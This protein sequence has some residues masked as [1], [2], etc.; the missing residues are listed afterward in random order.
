MPVSDYRVRKMDLDSYDNVAEGLE[1]AINA[2]A[3]E[4]WE[5][6]SCVSQPHHPD[7]LGIHE[8]SPTDSGEDPYDAVWQKPMGPTFYAVFRRLPIS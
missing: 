3:Q 7:L 1:S 8:T 2:L 6:V 4:G 5:F